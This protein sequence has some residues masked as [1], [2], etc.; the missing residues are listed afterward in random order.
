MLVGEESVKERGA[1][2]A[3]T[4]D[5]NTNRIRHDHE[6]LKEKNVANP[7]KPVFFF[8]KKKAL[9]ITGSTAL[10]WPLTSLTSH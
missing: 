7:W 9:E 2:K 8:N 5:G 1:C 10:A 4:R 6:L 3:T